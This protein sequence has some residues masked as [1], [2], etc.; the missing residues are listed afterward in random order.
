MLT[1]FSCS[2]CYP[3]L[4]WQLQAH[5]SW[6]VSSEERFTGFSPLPSWN[7]NP[8]PDAPRWYLSSLIWFTSSIATLP[9]RP[10]LGDR[11]IQTCQPCLPTLQEQQGSHTRALGPYH[12]W[13]VGANGHSYFLL[14]QVTDWRCW[15]PGSTGSTESC[16]PLKGEKRTAPFKLT[17][18]EQCSL[19]VSP[20][21]CRGRLKHEPPGRLLST[22]AGLERTLKCTQKAS[23]LICWP[24]IH[25]MI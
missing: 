12:R 6:T 18:W 19:G 14:G 17:E 1:S 24:Y 13:R 22:S 21:S 8:P 11:I 16:H 7:Q 25:Y 20:S 5:S 2:S 15:V 9:E 3:Q 23:F 10:A 4:N